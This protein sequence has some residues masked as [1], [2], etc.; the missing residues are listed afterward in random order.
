[1]IYNITIK[2]LQKDER[3]ASAKAFLS[4]IVGGRVPPKKNFEKLY[5]AELINTVRGMVKQFLRGK[6]FSTLNP[7]HHQDAPNEINKQRASLEFNPDYCNIQ[8]KLLFN[9]LPK[10][11]TL[12]PL[13]GEYANA[14]RKSFGSFLHF[15][16]TR[17]CGITSA[18][19]HNRVAA[20]VKQ[21]KMDGDGSY[22]HVAI[23]AL[24]DTIED[25][26]NIVKDKKGRI[27][28]IH[29]YEEF[30][31]EFIPPELKEHVKLLTNNYDLILSHIYQQFITTDV[32][33]TKKNLLN[34][35]EVQSKRNS[36]EL[37]AHFENMGV[38][39]QISDLGESVYSKAKWICYENLYINTM[40]VSTKEMNDFRTFQIKAVDLLDNSHGRD[41]LS[42]D[43][44]IKNIIKLGI[45]AA[46]GYDLQSSWLPLNAF[47]M[48]VFEEALVHSEHLVIKNLFELESQ[49]DF[50]ISA[51]IKFEKLKPIFY[52]DTPSSEK[53]NS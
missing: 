21:L 33:M 18:A 20:V 34:A 38:L 5:S 15:N 24:H 19:H 12:A 17:R 37:S 9:K 14:V 23:A 46:R 32:S 6:D 2:H 42:M 4:S 50:L 22:K 51:L 43:G 40:A 28:G 8:G 49:Q 10:E 27:Y 26:L 41:S 1:M 31:D 48:E 35:I 30:V 13:Y 7:R 36:G 53:S 3:Y 52:V 44:M 29:R 39:L 25:L 11:E 47:V 45:W 16:L